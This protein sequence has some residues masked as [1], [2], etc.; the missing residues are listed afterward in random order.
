[1][2]DLEEKKIENN[3]EL[4]EKAIKQDEKNKEWKKGLL[5]IICGTI[6]IAATGSIGYKLYEKR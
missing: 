3:N 5:G 1:M 4:V 2:K 6:V